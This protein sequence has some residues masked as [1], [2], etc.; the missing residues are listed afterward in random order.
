MY[1]INNKK[2]LP[3]PKDPKQTKT[4]PIVIFNI[5]FLHFH[6][7]YLFSLLIDFL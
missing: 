1:D 3:Y 4:L 2:K 7:D 6:K 5:N